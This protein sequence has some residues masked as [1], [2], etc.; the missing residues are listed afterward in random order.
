MCPLERGY[1][2][3]CGEYGVMAL[4]GIIEDYKEHAAESAKIAAFQQTALEAGMKSDSVA[5][6]IKTAAAAAKSAQES[7]HDRAERQSKQRFDDVLLLALYENGELDSF[8]G[9]N[10]FGGMSDAEVLN[11]VASVENETGNSFEDYAKNIMGEDMPARMVGEDDADYYRRVLIELTPYVLDNGE[12]RAGFEN[13]P[14][15][16]FLQDQEITKEARA[17]VAQHDTAA[18]TL[19]I[20]AV[21][22]A[23]SVDAEASL[24]V[25]TVMNAAAEVDELSAIGFQ[26][27]DNHRDAEFD[28]DAATNAANSFL[29]GFPGSDG[30]LETASADFA[31][32]FDAAAP[33]TLEVEKVESTFE[34]TMKT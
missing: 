16:K 18:K 31:S 8:I 6:V 2:D 22:V 19:G 7:L 12:I 1:R 5:G 11:V 15:A 24:A 33:D 21:A 9:E 29:A 13:D 32:Q 30:A 4:D 28:G 23:A 14:L 26:S 17:V 3:V 34:L 10:V 20:E 25:A 27:Q